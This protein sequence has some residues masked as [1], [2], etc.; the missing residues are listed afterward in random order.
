MDKSAQAKHPYPSARNHVFMFIHD[1][2]GFGSADSLP[3]ADHS[4]SRCAGAARSR[5]ARER[6]EPSEVV[7]PPVHTDIHQWTT[8]VGCWVVH[9]GS[10]VY[11]KC[12][13]AHHRPSGFSAATA[14][15]AVVVGLGEDRP[16][17][18]Q[19][20]DRATER[21]RGEALQDGRH[22]VLVLCARGAAACRRGGVV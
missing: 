2:P 3:T 6:R 15:P 11:K 21:E 12:G 16:E 17:R 7:C 20:T 9:R 13:R 5:T 10:R 1:P 22:R 14:F 19:V 8:K 4:S 18:Q